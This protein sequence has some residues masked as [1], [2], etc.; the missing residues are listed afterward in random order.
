MYTSVGVLLGVAL[1]AVTGIERRLDP[2]V[3]LV[4]AAN[5]V[6]TGVGLVRRSIDGLMDRALP[7]SAQA[8][9]KQA[10]AAYQPTGV[11]FHAVKTRQSGRPAFI[12]LH[13]LVPG[14]WTV[15][16]GHELLERVERDLR[17]AVPGATVFTHLEPDR[18]R[19][20]SPT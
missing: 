20:P 3:A 11:T 2:I 9:I 10:P 17:A 13:V 14:Y 1:V 18:T 16:A 15:H 8:A 7:A 19:R 5:I 12:S 4:V 6:V